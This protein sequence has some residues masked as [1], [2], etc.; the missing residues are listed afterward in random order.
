MDVLSFCIKKVVYRHF[1]HISIRLPKWPPKD[2]RLFFII[3][4]SNECFIYKQHSVNGSQQF[5]EW[6]W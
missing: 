1:F 2:M 4:G 3:I 5:V 6:F